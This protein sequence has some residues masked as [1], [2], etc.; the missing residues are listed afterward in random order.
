MRSQ[1]SFV[2][3]VVVVDIVVVVLIFVFVHIG[4]TISGPRTPGIGS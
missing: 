2:V 4:F 3:I 1:P